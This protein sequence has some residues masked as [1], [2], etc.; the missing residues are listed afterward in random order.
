[1]AERQQ[2]KELEN[3]R[4]SVLN[5]LHKSVVVELEFGFVQGIERQVDGL[6]VLKDRKQP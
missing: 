2:F 6:C 5:V 4:V 1:M 3:V